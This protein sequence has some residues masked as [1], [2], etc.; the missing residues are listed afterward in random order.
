MHAYHRHRSRI[1]HLNARNLVVNQKPAPF[2]VPG[3]SVRKK[4]ERN[5]HKPSWLAVACP[6]I[7]RITGIIIGLR[8]V[9][10]CT[11]RFSSARTFSFTM[12]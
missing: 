1:V 5:F 12:P 6:Q 11:S 9:V 8:P 10:F 7:S 2:F 4:R 3:R